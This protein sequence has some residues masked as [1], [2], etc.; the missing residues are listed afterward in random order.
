MLCGQFIGTRLGAG[1]V[2]TK[3]KINKTYAG[4]YLLF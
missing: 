2:L 1:L 4:H 3:G